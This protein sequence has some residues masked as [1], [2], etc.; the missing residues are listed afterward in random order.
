VLAFIGHVEHG[1]Y[2]FYANDGSESLRLPVSDLRRMAAEA[3]I[4]LLDLGCGTPV[5]A[6]ES[7]A[8]GALVITPEINSVKV[9]GRLAAA[10]EGNESLGEFYGSLA[11]QELKLLLT[12]DPVIALEGNERLSEFAAPWQIVRSN[13]H[14]R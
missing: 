11:E 10:V 5:A 14:P 2:V 12:P 7:E 13:S 3:K 1:A 9:V 8:Q 6:K 4:A